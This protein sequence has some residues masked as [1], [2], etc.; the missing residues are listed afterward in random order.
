MKEVEKGWNWKYRMYLGLQEVKESLWQWCQCHKVLLL[1]G[2]QVSITLAEEPIRHHFKMLPRTRTH[3]Q[4]IGVTVVLK[5]SQL[6]F[7]YQRKAVEEHPNH[8]RKLCLIRTHQ[9][10]RRSSTRHRGGEPGN[11]KRGFTVH[12]E[13]VNFQNTFA[14]KS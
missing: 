4:P 2:Q 9:E 8:R 6:P 13:S 7:F 14:R 11:P 5:Q 3:T 12:K 1:H 10:T